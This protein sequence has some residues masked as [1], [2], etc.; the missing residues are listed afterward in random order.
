MGLEVSLAAVSA[1]TGSTLRNP[2]LTPGK[3]WDCS[4]TK[5]KMRPGSFYPRTRA[6]RTESTSARLWPRAPITPCAWQ[7]PPACKQHF[8]GLKLGA[9]LGGN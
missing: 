9:R 2:R 3:A 1:R 5:E 7:E 4:S 8:G 6:G